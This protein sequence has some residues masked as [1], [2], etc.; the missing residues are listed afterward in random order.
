M[1][2][3]VHENVGTGPGLTVITTAASHGV[4]SAGSDGESS[5]Q[6]ATG[7]AKIHARMAAVARSLR[8]TS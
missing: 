6:P 4:G 2:V 8:L 1:Q 7:R 5:E 3:G